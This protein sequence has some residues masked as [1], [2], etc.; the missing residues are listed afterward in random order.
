MDVI[1]SSTCIRF[2][3]RTTERNYLTIVDEGG[4]AAYV[5]NLNIGPQKLYLRIGGGI[6]SMSLLLEL[7]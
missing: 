1:E 6:G 3:L 4:C 2:K 5:G 7:C